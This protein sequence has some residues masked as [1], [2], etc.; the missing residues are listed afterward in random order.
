LRVREAENDAGA[1]LT[2]VEIDEMLQRSAP[3]FHW[4]SRR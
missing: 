1:A 2:T 3:H 4:Q